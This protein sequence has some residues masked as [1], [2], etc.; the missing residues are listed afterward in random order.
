[1]SKKIT[2]LLLALLITVHAAYANT[3]D[4]QIRG[5]YGTKSIYSGNK[6]KV[7]IRLSNRAYN[8]IKNEGIENIKLKLNN[9]KHTKN[10]RIRTSDANAYLK[11][12]SIILSIPDGLMKR[13]G[14]H[15]L[16]IITSNQTFDNSFNYIPSVEIVTNSTGIEVNAAPIIETVDSNSSEDGLIVEDISEET[17]QVIDP[18]E[19][20]L[21]IS[22]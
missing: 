1:M 3:N 19:N 9:Y 5:Y 17:T 6:N 10:L 20:G 2:L 15:Y 22:F 11:G 21:E 18:S 14:V 13:K 7:H 16:S 12:R 4:I 8:S